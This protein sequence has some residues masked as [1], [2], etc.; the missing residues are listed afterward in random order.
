MEQSKRKVIKADS[1]AA[2]IVYSV[3]AHEHEAKLPYK[4]VRLWDKKTPYSVHP[5][6]AAMMLLQETQLPEEIRNNGYQALLL[7]DILE[8]TTAKLPRNI[9]P[10]VRQLVVD[11]TFQ[12]GKEA[13]EGIWEKSCVVKLLEL[14]DATSNFMDGVWLTDVQ[15]IKY[16]STKLKKLTKFVEEEYGMLNIVLLAKALLK[17]EKSR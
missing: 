13:S 5:V 4:K 2:L 1:I 10:I 15:K 16:R 8:D 9:S 7:H 14:Y 6:W 17:N 11:L 12:S 3:H